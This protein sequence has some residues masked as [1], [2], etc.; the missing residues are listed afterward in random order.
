VHLNPAH[1]ASGRLDIWFNGAFCGAYQ[2]A[3]ADP[4]NGARRNGAPF[5]NAQPRFGIYRDRRA[6]SQTIYFDSPHPT[7]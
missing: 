3:M 1:D 2:G 5:V 6:E 7:C 4:E